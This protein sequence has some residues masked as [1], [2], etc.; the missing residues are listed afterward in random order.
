MGFGVIAANPDRGPASKNHR[1]LPT[2]LSWERGGSVEDHTVAAS[3][4]E[5]L[6]QTLTTH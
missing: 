4:P 3:P 1:L 6:P 2:D 5:A